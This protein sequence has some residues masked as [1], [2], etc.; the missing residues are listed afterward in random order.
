MVIDQH[1]NDHDDDDEH[2]DGGELLLL[3][4]AQQVF[5]RVLVRRSL[6]VRPTLL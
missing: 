3:Q 5:E 4:V 2:L 1:Q 6:G